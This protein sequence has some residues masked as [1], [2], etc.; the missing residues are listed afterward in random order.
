MQ[1]ARPKS[2]SGLMLVGLGLM[3]VPLLAAILTALLQMRVLADTGQRIIVE[4]VTAARAS[5][6]L[7]AEIASLE[8]TARRF[9]VLN[10]PKLLELYRYEDERLTVP[11]D[12]LRRHATAETQRTLDE[13]GHLQTGT[14]FVVL[15]TPPSTSAATASDLS[16]RFTQLS[17]RVE[18]VAQQSNAAGDREVAAL[19]A[20]TLHA[21]Q[22]LLWESALLLPLAL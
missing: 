17:V 8:R 14:R 19:E 9:N 1:W 7:F 11:R 16:A 12:N 2:L 15:S 20:Q 21:R 13:L 18:Q 5:Q 4:G 22:Q 3:G 6:A 10:D